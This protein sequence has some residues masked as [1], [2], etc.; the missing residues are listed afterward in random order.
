[1]KA[2]SET[3]FENVNMFLEKWK[4]INPYLRGEV[5]RVV[6]QIGKYHSFLVIVFTQYFVVTQKETVS[7]TKS[8]NVKKIFLLNWSILIKP[9]HLRRSE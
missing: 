6:G 9:T 3:H 7:Y 4:V 2:H 8:E 1:M 5:G